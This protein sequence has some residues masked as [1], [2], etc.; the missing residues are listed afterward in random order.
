MGVLTD[1]LRTARMECRVLSRHKMVCNATL[2]AKGGDRGYF[3]AITGRSRLTSPG[4]DPAAA[5][6]RSLV[7]WLAPD[8][9][10][11]TFLDA[12]ADVVRAEICFA[13]GLA[14]PQIEH[15]PT[16]LR[17]A[18][19]S[20]SVLGFL[21]DQLLSE[22]SSVRPG[23]ER[24]CDHLTDLLV[25]Q[26]L[27]GEI[28]KGE[29]EGA[30]C[31]GLRGLADPDIG[32]ALRLMHEQPGAPWTVGSLAKRLA[33]SRSTFAARFKTMVSE[34]PL[35]YLTRLRLHRAAAQ[36][37]DEPELSL[38]VI[39]RNVGYQ[40]EAAFG[41]SFK[42]LFGT[43]PGVYRRSLHRLPYR[44]VSALQK[45]LKKRDAFDLPE[46]E[47]ELNLMRTTDYI[48]QEAEALLG[49]H[50]LVEPE[51]NILRILR[52]S[53]ETLSAEEIV[54]RMLTRPV[55]VKTTLASLKRNGLV[56]ALQGGLFRITP[57]GRQRL[58]RLDAPILDMHRR[59][60]AHLSALEREELNRLLVKVRRHP[61]Q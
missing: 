26:A 41:K 14:N 27:R 55:N 50:G 21:F 28:I 59:H 30:A 22:S 10:T 56:E 2:A 46:Q 11:L 49:K 57:R 39:A 25:V 17:A 8:E 36:M 12:E 16:L 15:L 6:P 58:A 45:E 9:H 40:T 35:G 1:I 48:R 7:I 33:I 4:S 23:W 29:G 43:S 13:G 53:S 18:V 44:H 37:R 42:R 20:A 38:P 47:V 60:L 54:S 5:E 52:G 31:P 19:A 51:F 34:T 24:T 61:G 32:A 3:Y